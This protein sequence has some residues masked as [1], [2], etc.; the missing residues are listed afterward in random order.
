V[1][2]PVSLGR[3]PIKLVAAPPE[4]GQHTHEVLRQFG[5]SDDEIAGLQ[6]GKVI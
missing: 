6:G 5:F 3:T 2:Q 4:A 1:G